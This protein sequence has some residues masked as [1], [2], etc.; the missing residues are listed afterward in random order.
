MPLPEQDILAQGDVLAAQRNPGFETEGLPSPQGF[1]SPDIP[2]VAPIP[3][4][5]TGATDGNSGQADYL[6]KF[7]QNI[8]GTQETLTPGN[9]PNYTVS[10][11]YNPRYRSI[12]PGE[13]SEEAFGK[14]QPWYDKWGNALVKFGANT[15]GTF[16]N[17]MASI[18]YTISSIAGGGTPYDN[19]I[20]R[21]VDN[22]LENMENIF[23]NY[24]T[25]WQQDH[26]FMS[27]VPFSG[28][29]ANFW[30]DK[31]I[32]NLGFTVGAIGSAVVTDTLVGA[33]TQGLGAAP[34]IANQVGKAALWLNKVFTGTNKAEQL[35][36]LGRAA[37]RTGEQLFNLKQLA[38]AAAAAKV[39]NGARFAIN[40]YGASA[41]EAGFEARDAFNTVR[42]DL[43]KAY[44]SEKGYSPVGADLDQ[45]EKYARS[46][47]NVRFGLNMAI[48]GL[49]NAIQFDSILKPFFAAKAGF[50][51]TIEK[52]I[53]GRQS[54]RLAEGS[55]DDFERVVSKDIWSKV[56]PVIPA[57]LSEGILEEGGQFATQIGVENFYERKYLYDKGL[58]KSAYSK[59]ET[60]FDSRDHV[61]NV[62]HSVVEGLSAEF[63]TDEGLENVLLGAI[64]GAVFTGAKN[65][66]DR[67]KDA[68]LTTTTLQLLNSQG[69]T[70]ILRNQYDSAA[71]AQRI[72]EDMKAA[73]RNNDIFK[74]KN[75]QHE[76]FV[77]FITSG[78]KAGR[79]DVRIEQLKMIKEMD[80]DEFKAAFGLDKTTDNVKTATEYVDALITKAEKIKK[81]YDLINDTFTNPF[82]SNPK[83]T[84]PQGAL[85]NQ[86]HQIFESWKDELT[87]YASIT[88]DVDA[89]LQSI[90]QDLRG[91][92]RNLDHYHVGNFTDRKFLKNY[93]A[94][95]KREVSSLQSLLDSNASATP[96]E[97]RARIATLQRKIDMIYAAT[98]NDNV[99]LKTFE[100][101]FRTILNFHLN[102]RVDEGFV[103]IP[104]EAIPKLIE[105]GIDVK[106]LKEYRESANKAFDKLSTPEGF[107]RY[108]REVANVEEAFANR[109]PPTP[110]PASGQQPPQ[111]PI[112]PTGGTPGQPGTPPAQPAP[113]PKVVVRAKDGTTKEFEPGVESYVTIE[114]DKDPVKGVV[115]EQK[116]DGKIVVQTPDG[117][118]HEVDQDVFFTT[119]KNAEAAKTEVDT[120]TSVEDVLPTVPGQQGTKEGPQK[121]DLSFALFST[122]DPVYSRQD[123]PFDNFHRRHQNFLFAMGHSD[124]D[125]FNQENK[126]KLRIIPVTAKTAAALGFPAGFITDDATN[127]DTATIRAVYVIDDTVEPVKRNRQKQAL[128]RAIEKSKKLPEH[129]K[130]NVKANPDRA[131]QELYEQAVNAAGAEEQMGEKLVDQLIDYGSQGLFFADASGNK[132]G[133]VGDRVNPDEAIFTTFA[134]TDLTFQAS[135]GVTE[136]R[137]TNKENLDPVASV[138]WWRQQRADI[139]SIGT[140]QGAMQRV[141]Q[142]AVSRGIPNIVN[143]G[144]RNSAVD[145][146]LITE[147]D[148]DKPII[149]IPT[150]GDTAIMGALNEEGEG[151]PASKSGVNMPLG[152]P[153]LNHGGNLVFLNS[154]TFNKAEAD[155]I[156]EM[157]KIISDRNRTVDSGPLFKYLHKVIYMANPEKGIAPTS[158]SI[159]ITKD[160][161]LILGRAADQ[162]IRLLPQ[163]LDSEK[164]RILE[165]LQKSYHHVKNSE[166]LRIQRDPKAND[167][168]FVELKAENGAVEVVNRWK[169]YNHYLLSNRTPQGSQ[170]PDIPLAV[171]ILVPQQGESPIIQKYSEILSFDFDPSKFR[172]PEQAS[173]TSPQPVTEA[174]VQNAKDALARVIADGKVAGMSAENIRALK[175]VYSNDPAISDSE[176]AFL[177]GAADVLIE[178]L[179]QKDK[180]QGV[181]QQSPAT[182]IRESLVQVVN[183][184][185]RVMRDA[186]TKEELTRATQAYANLNPFDA[187]A[188]SM[189]TRAALMTPGQFDQGKELLIQELSYVA[190]QKIREAEAMIQAPAETQQQSVPEAAQV[191]AEPLQFVPVLGKKLGFRVIARDA[192]GNITDIH[193]EGS[194][195]DDGTITPF[196]DPAVI[197]D[198]I[199]FILT[200]SRIKQDDTN[201][202]TTQ[203]I[204]DKFKGRN[205]KR[206]NDRFRRAYPGNNNYVKGDIDKEFKEVKEILNDDFFIFEKVDQMLQTTGGGLAWGALENN[207]IYVYKNA[208]VGTTYHEAFE[209][210]W[211]HFVP[212]KEQQDIY[213]EF[214]GRKGDF[215]TYA[216]KKKKYSEATVKEAK[217]QL[218]EEF[219]DY[220]I[221]G[222]LPK[223][224][225]QRSFFQRLLKFI[226]WLL[227][228]ESSDRNRLFKK[229]NKGYYRGFSTSLRGPMTRPEYAYYREPG[230]SE[231]PET[232]VQDMLQG[233]TAELFAEI[234]GENASI[235]DQLEEDFETTATSIYDRLKDKLTYYFEDEVADEGTLFAEVGYDYENAANDDDRDAIIRQMDSIRVIWN[236]IKDNWGSFVKEHERYLRIFNV[237]FVQDDEGN[238]ELAQQDE[239]DSENK[240]QTEYERDIMTL[241]AK[242]N[243]SS[244]VK[245]LIASVADSEWTR[246][247]T[248]AAMTAADSVRSKREASSMRLPKLASYAKLFNYLLHNT[249]GINGIYD[250]WSKLTAMTEDTVSRKL[251]DANVRKLMSRVKLDNGFE[252]KTQ[253]DVRLA[254][255]L[256]NTLVKQKPAFFRQFTDF[257]RNTYFKTTVLNSKIEQVKSVWIASIK[258]SKAIIPSAENRFLFSRAV[259]GTRNNIEFLNR[260]GIDITQADYRRLR[261]ANVTKFN[262]AVNKIR[263]LVERAARDSIAIPIVSSKQLDFDSRLNDL[264]DLYVVHMVGEDTQSQH[265]NLDGEQTSNFV[266][267]N[268]VSTMVNDAN[269]AID[270]EDFINRIDNEY[271]NDIFHNDSIL[272]N[273]VMFDAAGEKNKEV[274]VGVV[275]GRETWDRNNRSTSSLTEAERLLYEINNNLNGVFYT[276][277]PA[278]AK[279]EWAINVGTYLSADGFFGDESSRSNEV[280]AFGTQM[281]K[282]LQTEVALARDFE[283]RKFIDALNRKPKGEDREVGKSLRFFKDILPKTLVDDIH[284]RVI[285]GSTPLGE[286]VS[287][288]QMRALMREYVYTRAQDTLKELVDWKLV[289][290]TSDGNLV[291]Y[292]FDKIFIDKHLGKE[293]SHSRA[294]IERLLAFREMNYVMNNI[295][296]HK[297]FFG[298][299]AQYKDELKRIKSFLSGRE[300]T[301]VDMN[302]TSEG[303]NQWA[304]SELNK[305]GQVVLSPTDPGYQSF[306]NHFN[307]ITALDVT[308]ESD[309]IEELEKAIGKKAASP[310]TEGNE[311]DAGAYM[312]ATAMREMLWKAGGRWT[313]AQ[314]KQFQWEMAWERDDKAKEGKYTYPSAALRE[315]DKKLLETEPDTE[316]AFPIL[317]LMHSGIQTTENVAIV[318][319]DK[320]SWAPLF[321]RWYKGKGLGKLYDAMQERGI[322]YIRMESAHKVGIQKPSKFALYTP[323]GEI[324]VETFRGLTPE[325]V[326]IKQIGIQV[327]QSKKE[328]GQTEGS[329]LRKIAIGD[330]RENG[331]PI[332]YNGTYNEWNNLNEEQRL[333]TS[334]IYQKI[335]R[336]NDALVALT[337]T[338]TVLTMRRLG[339]E[340]DEGGTVTIPDK[341]NISDFILAELERREL[342]ISPE[343]RDFSNPLEANPQYSKIRAIIYSILEK[344]ITRPKVNGGQ[345]TLLSVTGMETGPRVVK[346]MV[347]G[348]PVYTSNA[349]KF[350]KQNDSGTE[351]C[352]IMLPYWFGK[353]L[354]EAGS[355][356]TKEEILEYLNSTEEGQK[357]LRGIGFRIP[358]QGLNSVDFFIVKDFLPEQM[359]DVIVFPSEI[360]VK[361]GSDFDIDKMNVYLYNYY[362]NAKTGYPEILSRRGSEEE[363]KAYIRTLIQDGII[364]DKQVQSAIKDYVEEEEEEGVF[365]DVERR[366]AVQ[367]VLRRRESIVDFYYQKMLENEYFSSIEA[368][369]SLPENYSRLITPNDASELKGYRDKMLKLKGKSS[370]PLGDY[371]KLLSS[372][373]MMKERQAYMS[374]KQV[375]G[376]S[377]VSQTAQAIAQNLEGGLLIEDPS[378]VARFP[379]NTVGGKISLSSLRVHGSDKFISNINSQ[380]TDGGVDV[381]KDKFL[382]EMEVNKDTLSTFL[383]LVRMGADPWWAILYLNQPS[384]QEFLKEK[385]ISKSVSQ[386][387]PNVKDDNDH[388]LLTATF[389]KFGG[390]SKGKKNL[391]EKPKYYS[392]KQMEEMIE[393]YAKDPQSL[394]AEQK[395]LQ[396]MILD[397]FSNYDRT[398]GKW[399]GYS[400]LAWDLFH[401]YQGYNWDTARM[402][403]PNL[404][405]LKALKYEKANNL[406]ITQARKVME[407][408]FIGAMMQKIL[409]LDEGLRSVINIQHGAAGS[410]L[411]EI[412]RDVFKMAGG[413]AV[414]QQILMTA[415]LSMV[416]YAVQTNAMVEGRPLNTMISALL[417]SNRA[418]A[419]YLDAIRKYTNGDL[420]DKDLSENPMIKAIIPV[421]DVRPGF[422]S[423]IVM[424]ERDYETYTS[425]ILTDSFRQLRDD[426]PVISINDNEADSRTVAQIYKRLVLTALIQG[427]AKSGKG[428]F[429]HL[430]PSETYSEIVRDS[431]R[432]M[433]LEGFY[434]NLAL[435]R[436]NWSNTGLVPYATMELSDEEYMNDPL[437]AQPYYH[438]F[439]NPRV[440]ATLAKIMNTT[441]VPLTL[442]QPANKYRKHKVIKMEELTR[443]PG[444]GQIID[445]KVRLFRRVDVYGENG[446]VPLQYDRNRVIY[447]EINP[448]GDQNIR[449]FY[450]GQ[451][452]SVLPHNSKVN[453]ASDDQILYAMH[454]VG[455]KTNASEDS[456][457]NVLTTFE[458]DGY[459]SGESDDSGN[460][461]PTPPSP[462]DLG[463]AG[464]ATPDDM[465]Q[466]NPDSDYSLPFA[467]VD[468]F[469]KFKSQLIKKC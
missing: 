147:R 190:E 435:Y 290:T 299:P 464:G 69:V 254:L 272:L 227:G 369:V 446:V 384:I 116:P 459:E 218:A 274:Q 178:H 360:T 106:R 40:L 185:I 14:A 93:A 168:E 129:I 32:K 441:S 337:T 238:T 332:D 95:L 296:M 70:G 4:P 223:Q 144:T 18:P 229:M 220:K 317:K 266:L 113:P 382:A 428:Q 431:L 347:N 316:V 100:N 157:L 5:G 440:N 127:A 221:S 365:A 51:S 123:M 59:D 137:Y 308:F 333:A 125:V 277:L 353:K 203:T 398:Q 145:V 31:F 29:F 247:A 423:T 373:Y 46:A 110:P 340:V 390:V 121:K 452:Q 415:E 339:M 212:G 322:D 362:I 148:L 388:T 172:R 42:E 208:E 417:L 186:S 289:H 437:N 377:A 303:F 449:E 193:P 143:N 140:P 319:L 73:V 263:S 87:F 258:G 252:G 215:V 150:L 295:E 327:E 241:D 76:Q 154:R 67:S 328:K 184:Q 432:N 158:S 166:L 231:F 355:G 57:I 38:Q 442:E 341:K 334:P 422:P 301:H 320:A 41:A 86:K 63:G 161:N 261:G 182:G 451:T 450:N 393:A 83:D 392:M 408:T 219:R 108:F 434:E 26:P 404:V 189:G 421:I 72:S 469:E 90:G 427:G 262:D 54:V 80:N 426:A 232:I 359:G 146:H 372:T 9:L 466:F 133:R 118:T 159:T 209:A 462:S 371:G 210:V 61:K 119:D 64:T 165:F 102:G 37:G 205:F 357:L 235:I 142:F 385:A 151:I 358:T 361:A 276:L 410:V 406:A 201:T 418:T 114:K 226:K 10:D 171:N 180:E 115:I 376:I 326:P 312:T 259:I 324:D 30:G 374:S 405:R 420:S 6:A 304:N 468:S 22:W 25:K 438:W 183:A 16:A 379:A 425:N 195:N 112:P 74:Y 467:Q 409:Q 381:A 318:S 256:E 294:A 394:T 429:A 211:Y 36:L 204:K 34:L 264:A 176:K 419:I 132:M 342:P 230:L 214:I 455:I 81:S 84:S 65:F 348:K 335:K 257:Q 50:R 293:H 20:G 53:A 96:A 169:N 456:V 17:G 314:E 88:S 270:R 460:E 424:P 68:Q 179:Q 11:V 407:D 240:R 458:D 117:N 285:D 8:L 134:T 463:G 62:A 280:T 99:P 167:L 202:D 378:Y 414:K 225:K 291:L 60:P 397:D 245:L 273:K 399:K 309:M 329:Q 297:F 236:R 286:V 400:G 163:A 268:F 403:D 47:G 138:E 346:K 351:A 383:A 52:G 107:E 387:N 1:D 389:K 213:N 311:D 196:K 457:Y 21:T 465:R 298:D 269:Q 45:I 173:T 56:R 97:D 207:M 66:M 283:N 364:N 192:E 98:A 136:E 344:T 402:N 416:D 79:Y 160:G 395:L 281:Y 228:L 321:Y 103:N 130:V 237:E 349:L 155:N 356:R 310:Y 75:F 156:F 443:D 331:V 278:D 363:T 188:V 216:G 302:G 19:E 439:Y 323:E 430:I 411:D 248:S 23:P 92:E 12:L 306:K 15:V 191:Q 448:W 35:M 271:F 246:N 198:G 164:D 325:M 48:L 28:G 109:T 284:S 251:I 386:I 260:I 305:A 170:R 58:D 126:P 128:L 287:A 33:L 85:E 366:I 307:T 101:M 224:P 135:P 370:T 124:P 368:L 352:E 24:Y 39:A 375:V 433:Q 253:A 181:Q 265:P 234:F 412:A 55:I 345:K 44:I 194:I 187:G 336:H 94:D 175:D 461:P 174:K 49:S 217:E 338:R 313:N 89:R 300:Y 82:V 141:Y 91:I 162:P 367:D 105:Y 27:A 120:N 250:I 350:Y 177:L 282:W 343:T 244:R 255:S 267:N 447:T 149:T 396:M 380:T 78:A 77:R 279:T 200:Q 315:H 413:E 122:T 3:I 104:Q 233:M 197:K 292:G 131:I 288:E 249:A 436:G 453:E 222:T 243:A 71:T 391:R 454:T 330:L 152:T 444:T 7:N 354:M 199:L 242:N 239:V 2:A 275:E 445:R 43:I 153:L 111:G 206:G 13:D 139:L 401:F